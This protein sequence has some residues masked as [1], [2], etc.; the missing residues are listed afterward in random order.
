[1]PVTHH[2]RDRHGQILSIL[3]L[4]G[5]STTPS[6][7]VANREEVHGAKE[8]SNISFGYTEEGADNIG[9]FEVGL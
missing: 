3:P 6:S 2:W 1:M 4:E 9:G 7:E 5:A 8:I